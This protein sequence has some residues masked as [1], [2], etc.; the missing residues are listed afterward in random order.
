MC[1]PLA[2]RDAPFLISSTSAPKRPFTEAT[3]VAVLPIAS[4][5][6]AASRASGAVAGERVGGVSAALDA[7]KHTAAR[8]KERR[9]RI[10]RSEPSV[11]NRLERIAPSIVRPVRFL[12]ALV[13]VVW[14]V[15]GCGTRRPDSARPIEVVVATEASTLDPRFATRSLD[16]KVTRLIHAG[17][18]GLDPSTLEP[19]PLVAESVRFQGDRV[20]DVVLRPGIHF[21]GGQPLRP[22]DVCGTLDAVRDPALGS[23][24][25]TIVSSIGRCVPT[26]PL[27]LRIELDS[28]RATILTDL[29]LPILRGD[30]ARSAPGPDLLLDG[31][32]PF[33]VRQATPSAVEL[34]PAETNV[35]PKPK[36][37]VVVRTVRDENARVQRL[38][39]GRA[40]VAPNSVSPTLMPALDGREGLEI[41]SRGGANVTYLLFQNDRAPFDR[42][43]VRRAV[44]NALDRELIAKTLLAGRAV[45][46][47]SVLPP[48]HWA[49]DPSL[50]PEPFDP[51]KARGVLAG[52]R[53]ASL[54]TST[55]R[56]RV[57]LARAVGQMLGDAGLPTIVVPIDLGV[58]FTRLDAGDFDMALLQLPE[59]TEPNVLSW[60]F[61]PSGVPGE[62]GMGKNRARYRNPVARELFDDASRVVE[63][64]KRQTDYRTL[65]RLMA[66]DVPVV[67]LF[68]ED[69][70][71]VVSS[72]ARGFSLSAEGRWMSL[73]GLE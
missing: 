62:G 57:T 70:V 5:M 20:V 33:S 31:L 10:T 59:L 46:A 35:F 17:L 12:F 48:G 26:G 18:V 63:K 60:F 37:A 8:T 66:T 49:A 39:A 16:V 71:A 41:V 52:L 6:D 55:D 3:H 36:H 1:S 69:Q 58:L 23:P 53:E 40:D 67:P 24:H 65:M 28:P 45:A 72:R 13:A 44:A 2:P 68:H 29:E 50:R 22:E 51:A 21:H 4:R 42:V 25:R 19:T 34:E 14:G 11:A 9:R 32:G 27:A 47:A 64:A 43:D 30:Q 15:A 38:L 61:N 56:S 54:L 7:A 73:A